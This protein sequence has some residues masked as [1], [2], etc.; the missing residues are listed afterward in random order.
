MVPRSEAGR[1]QGLDSRSSA[2]DPAISLVRPCAR[3]AGLFLAGSN[4][5]V[6]ISNGRVSPTMTMLG[7]ILLAAVIC[8]KKQQTTMFVL[9]LLILVIAAT[10]GIFRLNSF[11]LGYLETRINLA[12][13][14][15]RRATLVTIG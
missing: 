3:M 14:Q 6:S 11:P 5:S 15:V 2:G 10:L 8:L 13:K 1:V 7:S 9:L 12:K 4:S